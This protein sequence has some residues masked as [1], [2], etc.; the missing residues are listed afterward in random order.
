MDPV[1]A[2]SLAL[3]L[4]Q[5]GT[6]IAEMANTATEEGR[7]LTPQELASINQQNNNAHSNLNDAINNAL[8][9]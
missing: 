9:Q 3:G 8:N 2:M 4:L 1:T 5:A 6:K 7:D